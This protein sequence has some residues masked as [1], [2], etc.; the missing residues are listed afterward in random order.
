M[1]SSA[2]ELTLTELQAGRD[3]PDR[4]LLGHPFNPS[5]LIRSHGQR[6]DRRRRLG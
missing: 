5:H 4:F 2:S 1:P 6:A 3:H